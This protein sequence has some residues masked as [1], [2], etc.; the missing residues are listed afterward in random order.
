MLYNMHLILDC[1]ACT[2]ILDRTNDVVQRNIL[3]VLASCAD[4][5]RRMRAILFSPSHRRH[6]ARRRALLVQTVGVRINPS[7]FVLG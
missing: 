1:D 6:D 2:I 5:I 7:L 3:E 4:C